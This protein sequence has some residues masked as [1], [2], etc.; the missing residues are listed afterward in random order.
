MTANHDGI[1]RVGSRMKWYCE[2]ANL[3]LKEDSVGAH[4]LRNELWERLID[5]Y[6]ALLSFLIRS[7]GYCFRNR[8]IATVRDLLIWDDWNG[9]VA[10]IEAVESEFRQ[11]KN[12]YG[13]EI[14]RLTLQEHLKVALEQEKSLRS[15]FDSVL[16]NQEYT[17]SLLQQQVSQRASDKMEEKDEEFIDMLCLFDPQY[18]QER[19]ETS[20]GGL[21]EAS[22]NWILE[23]FNQWRDD[24]QSRLL[25][26]EG[27][28][29]KGKTMLMCG[30]MKELSK[31]ATDL[32]SY[33]FCQAGDERINNAT[34][35]LQGL[36]YM[37]IDQQP[38]LIS[39][40]RKKHRIRKTISESPNA[41]SV[42]SKIFK[43]ILK[44]PSLKE[45]YVIIDALDEC[46]ADLPK[47]LEL[48]TQESSECSAS[49]I[50]W[51]VS[52]RPNIADIERTLRPGGPRKKWNLDG[53]NYVEP[54]ARVVDMY[55]DRS[56]FK[57]AKHN[58]YDEYD[59]AL[60]GKV[61]DKLR[62]KANGTF[63]WVSLVNKSLENVKSWNV[64]D[65]VDEMPSG[66]IEL[67][68]RMLDQIQALGDGDAERCRLVL[69]T[70]TT[71]KEPLRLEELGALSGLPKEVAGKKNVV[72]ELVNMCGSFLTVQY[73]SVYIVHQSANDFLWKQGLD[74][75]FPSGA[76]DVHYR[77]FSA[78]IHTLLAT[79]ERNMYGLEFDGFPIDEAKRPQPDPLI[80]ARYGCVY[81]VDH[82][83][84]YSNTLH[85]EGFRG[86]EDVD[87]FMK[88][89]Y[90]YWL[91]ALSLCRRI[92]KGVE[93]VAKLEALI[94][95]IRSF[96]FVNN[97]H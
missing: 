35:V 50:K 1:I 80:A 69:S 36:L 8:F 5:L 78:S 21:L 25:W 55:I 88:E 97:I 18:D 15:N 24:K 37:I 28:P 79:L 44:D 90:L 61:R 42:L 96:A 86:E 81:W 65:R 7:V 51:V 10:S 12:D 30:I 64:L 94:Q 87:K 40:I 93:S 53:N 33:F 14:I 48:I 85:N 4:G 34:A 62:Q 91:E 70:V 13:T 68:Q 6:Q 82:L 73:D 27:S 66:L 72:E 43:D 54:M 63:L 74:T 58:K 45:T 60:Q 57:L 39:N 46:V 16:K 41:Y 19:I 49:R 84:E 89:K 31:S 23:D 20:K 52:S 47:L 26:I 71:A 77:I 67:Y 56:V 11:D 92:S 32:L 75:I 76:S 83:C 38:S 22:Y 29:G 3:L 9:A 2:L 59:K 17:N 95:V